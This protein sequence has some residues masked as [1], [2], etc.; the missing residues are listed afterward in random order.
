[1]IDNYLRCMGMYNVR[2]VFFL[3]VVLFST[4][5]SCNSEDKKESKA[6]MQTNTIAIIL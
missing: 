1:M 3:A 2:A 5:V 4:L 6:N